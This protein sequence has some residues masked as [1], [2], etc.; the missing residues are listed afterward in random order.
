MDQVGSGDAERLKFA[1]LDTEDLAVMSAHLQDAWATVGDMAY[2]PKL[3]RF[4]MTVTRVDWMSL[5]AGRQVRRNAG[6][7]FEC[8]TRARHVGLPLQDPGQR[9]QLL[10][11][12]F[13]P[14]STPAGEVTLT[15]SGEASVKLD[16]ECLEAEMRDLCGGWPVEDCPRHVLD[17]AVAAG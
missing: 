14:T 15:F 16:V 17:E 3:R 1:V 9:L 6:F 10:S 5:S 11:V 4:A 8:V 2:L 12:A 7:H 13:T